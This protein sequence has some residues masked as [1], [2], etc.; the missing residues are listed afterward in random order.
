MEQLWGAGAANITADHLARMRAGLEDWDTAE[1]HG[2]VFAGPDRLRAQAYL[3]N[4]REITV[5]QILNN[6]R[7]RP[8][9]FSAGEQYMYSSTNY[10]LMGLL[11]ANLTNHTSWEDYLQISL[12]SILPSAASAEYDSLTFARHGAPMSDYTAVHGEDRTSFNGQ[13]SSARPGI[14]TWR[15]RNV[16]TGWTASNMVGTATDAARLGYD[17]MGASEPHL[18]STAA[19]RAML[20]PPRRLTTAMKVPPDTYGFGTQRPHVIRPS[21]PADL[22]SILR[23]PALLAL[24]DSPRLASPSV[25]TP[26]P[27]AL[28]L[29]P[30]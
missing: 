19:S 13:S 5:A 8:M 23:L 27:L 15:V 10:V 12:L 18:L 3:H 21:Q 22:S 28:S 16:L 1:F 6:T 14:D 25:C 24:P 29:I 26:S 17:L 30:R 2:P 4:D 11:L 20:V 7:A 9:R